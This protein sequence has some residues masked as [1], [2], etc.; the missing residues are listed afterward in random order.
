MVPANA[1]DRIMAYR[2]VLAAGLIVT[3]ALSCT[4]RG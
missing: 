4:A 2:H 1:T 3:G